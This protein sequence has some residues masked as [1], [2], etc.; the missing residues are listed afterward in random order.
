V[1]PYEPVNVCVGPFGLM[2]A[3]LPLQNAGSEGDDGQRR[4]SGNRW[5]GSLD[6][7]QARFFAMHDT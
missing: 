1:I 6:Q 5:V 3:T 2:Q 4:I 7:N